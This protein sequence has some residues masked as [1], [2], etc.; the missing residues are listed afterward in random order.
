MSD[1]L[2]KKRILFVDDDPSLLA[3]LQNV[4]HRDRKRWDMTFALGGEAALEEL[5]ANSFDVVVSDM[6]MPVIDGA[7][8]LA[9]VKRRAPH[10]R[11]V[12]LSGSDCESVAGDVDELLVKPC[13]AVTLRATLERLLGKPR[14]NEP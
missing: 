2:K 12:M 11:R 3:G 1:E 10:T 7:A 14:D 6:R 4:L 8:V 5:G 9:I 13:S